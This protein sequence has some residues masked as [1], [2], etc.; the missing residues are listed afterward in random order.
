MKKKISIILSFRN[1][2]DNIEEFLRRTEKTFLKLPNWNYEIIFINDAS[3]DKSVEIIKNNMKKFDIKLITM[4]RCFGNIPCVLA[5]FEHADGDA[6]IYI[7]LDLQDPP[8]LFFEMIKKH[9]EGFEIVHTKR[10]KRLNENFI[11]NH[12][13]KFAYKTINFF[14]F[15]DLPEEF[16]NFK[17]LSRKAF[18][19]IVE[20]KEKS[21]YLRGVS[22]WIGFKSTYIEYVRQGRYKGISKFTLLN[23]AGPYKELIRGI[24]SYSFAPLY[25]GYFFSIFCLVSF[26]F[27][28]VLNLNDVFI[29]DKGI[30]FILL[31]ILILFFGIFLCIGFMGSYIERIYEQNNGRKNFIISEIVTSKN[32]E[33]K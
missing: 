30:N 3:T 23:S 8:E 15:L 33:N 4:S 20:Q 6:L 21:P 1:E 13:V 27:L 29:I 16:G 19:E 14:S 12:L 2:E 32:N 11:K 17:L 24:V 26:L 5:G 7:D 25:F 28:G 22:F 9:E 18:R 10:I 31:S